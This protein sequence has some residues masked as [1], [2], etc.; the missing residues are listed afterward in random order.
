MPEPPHFQLDEY[1]LDLQKQGQDMDILDWEQT[2][3]NPF[4]GLRPFRTR[5]AHLFF[6]RE[7]QAEELVI[8][9]MQTH[10]LGVLG[11]SGSGKSSLVRAGLIP[12]L[13][14]GKKQDRV[15]D[16]RI[17]ICRPGNSP[18][19]NLAAALA[20]AHQRSTDRAALAPEIGRLLPL[21]N[22][23][24]FG[25]LKALQGAG[26]YDKTL[27]VADQFE[28]LFRFG[29]EIP[30]GE[31]AHFVDLLLTAS[32]QQTAEIYVVLTMRS[33]FLGECVRYRGLPEIINQ[34]Q[35]LVPRLSGE[36]VRRAV[37][38]PLGVVGAPLDPTLANRLVR[39]VGD[40]MDQLPLLQHAL[41][42]TYRHW[43]QGGAGAPIGHDDFEA[44]GQ[45]TGALGRH[46]EERY[47]ALNDREKAIAKLLFQR[48][49]DR[50]AGDKGGRRPTRMVEIY[51]LARAIPAGREEVDRV[52]EQ[53][54]QIDTSFLMPPPGAPLQEEN[55]LDISH[56]SLL[57]NW[58][59]LDE[60]ALEEADNARQYQR[61][62]QAR[63]DNEEDARQG[64][65]G[66]ARLEHLVEWR[67]KTPV[68]YFWAA[69]YHPQ[70][71]VR[72]REA[73]WEPDREL[74]ERNLAFLNASQDRAEEEERRRLEY[75]AQKLELEREKAVAERERELRE[76]A[77]RS[78]RRAY[79][80]ARAAIV[81]SIFSF[82]M[83]ILATN[84]YIDSMVSNG[85]AFE[86]SEAYDKATQAYHA[87]N[88]I[89]IL[90]RFD[91]EKL[92]DSVEAK[93]IQQK[94]YNRLVRQGDSSSN[95]GGHHLLNALACYRRAKDTGYPKNENAAAKMAA[96]EAQRPTL[97]ATFSSDGD[98]YFEAEAYEL[99]LQSYEVALQM[100][101][102]P[103]N[104]DYIRQK[105]ERTK[106]KMRQ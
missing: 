33:E 44:V 82:L 104:Q 74:F 54:R 55:M 15:A 6:G 70:P 41:M 12:A 39:E 85:K 98:V 8:R 84:Y 40:N 56:E 79:V 93:L 59:R 20:G 32:Q 19:Q 94:E 3:Q 14:G 27:I 11:N 96:I 86:N 50:S 97:A 102:D 101:A 62:Q 78:E 21:L 29:H 30:P 77:E 34:G 7:G 22:N 28:E 71:A 18:V 13:H 64:W 25:L 48:L 73:D 90:G 53:F 63:E 68:N 38:G 2:Q 61:L 26:A 51:G 88:S 91:L 69:R 89:D 17:V 67:E 37:A 16:W 5:E 35:Y 80:W 4:P 75:E 47:Q 23:S 100:S 72:I 105:I 10:F 43:Q 58:E 45:M 60:W 106:S 66:G 65:I 83:G 49:T 92:L 57:R 9:L 99:A 31:A 95:L 36:N 1:Y 46:A 76:K 42:R 52:I 24:S 103:A 87:A 81:A